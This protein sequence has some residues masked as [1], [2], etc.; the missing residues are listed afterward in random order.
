MTR[1][2]M[3]KSLLPIALSL[4]LLSSQSQAT[5]IDSCKEQL[6]SCEDVL[7]SGDIVIKRQAETIS[8]LGEQNAALK[9]ALETASPIV[10]APPTPWYREPW[11]WFIIGAGAGVAVTK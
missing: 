3:N 8:M 5:V 7:A 11:L 4:A 9:R 2:L 6:A 10:N 1:L